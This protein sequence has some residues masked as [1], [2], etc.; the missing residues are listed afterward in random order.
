MQY[1]HWSVC[2]VCGRCVERGT[3]DDWLDSPWKKDPAYRVVRCPKHWSEWA[4]RNSEAGRTNENR[5][6]L[7]RLQRR[8]GHWSEQI[9]FAPLPLRDLPSSEVLRGFTPSAAP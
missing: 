2:Q 5:L 1:Q 3:D 7:Y 4:L 6:R 9:P 8:Y